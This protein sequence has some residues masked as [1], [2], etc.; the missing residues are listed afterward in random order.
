VNLVDLFPTVFELANVPQSI[1]TDGK[2]LVPLLDKDASTTIDM[3][4][5][6]H[7]Y[8]RGSRMGYSVRTDRYRYTEWHDN[9]Y[10][11]YKNYDEGN[12]VGREFYDYESDPLETKN[13]VKDKK[14]ASVVKDL[15]AKLKAHLT[16]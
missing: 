8:A 1:Q 7:Q 14:Y 2:S 15:K 6:Y 5:A 4:Y 13:W 11:S 10:R 12:I 9:N 16:K 3:D